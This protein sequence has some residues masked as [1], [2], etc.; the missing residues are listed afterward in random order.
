MC[1]PVSLAVTSFMV[2]AGSAV[3]NFAA[4]SAQADEQNR[5]Y[6]K[7]AQNAEYSAAV[8]RQQNALRKNQEQ[9]AAG[10]KQFD[11]FL[12][13]RARASS[14]EVAAGEAGVT[15]LS[16]DSLIR[17]VWQSGG[18]TADRIA[19][20]SEMT[21][22]Q[23]N[24]EDRAIEARKESRINSVRK[25]VAPSGLALGLNIASAGLGAAKDY[26]TMTK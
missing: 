6:E 2:T 3:S 23:L 12:E 9:E 20:N 21:L 19:H 7:N 18:R 24:M 8:E 17:D 22:Q 26:K 1:D 14:A 11:N 13:T 25:G 5:M 10:A 4:A 15:G 16:V